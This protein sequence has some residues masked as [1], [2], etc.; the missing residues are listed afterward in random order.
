MLFVCDSESRWKCFRNR[1]ELDFQDK[2]FLKAYKSHS[3]IEQLHF[4]SNMCNYH[5]E[6][7]EK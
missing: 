1:F 7:K 5:A 6:I 4:G 2:R 3:I